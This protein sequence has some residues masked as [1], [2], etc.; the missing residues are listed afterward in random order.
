MKPGIR[1]QLTFAASL[2]LL[3]GIAH[4]VL[5]MAQTTRGSVLIQSYEDP[6]LRPLSDGEVQQAV[7]VMQRDNRYVAAQASR[8]RVEMVLATSMAPRDK[9]EPAGMR[10]AHV[11]TYNYDTNETSSAVVTLWPRE[12]LEHYDVSAG[13]PPLLSPQE[14]QRAKALALANAGVNA[15]LQVAGLGGRTGELIITH[16]LAR[17]AT[18]SDSCGTQRCVL[19]MIGT[20]EAVLDGGV[21]VNLTTGNVEVR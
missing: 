7:Q 20:R 17:G 21:L 13:P 4:P 2:S 3:V 11:V 14:L 10:R 18:P 19:L 8:Q 12:Q 1:I 6:A 5:S 16:L 9:D 15:R